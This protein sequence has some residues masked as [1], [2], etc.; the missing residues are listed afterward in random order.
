MLV[1]VSASPQP[2]RSVIMTGT[3][4]KGTEARF[5]GRCFG[6]GEVGQTIGSLMGL[7]KNKEK[8]VAR[9]PAWG[10]SFFRVDLPS[11]V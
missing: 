5:S 2:S 8:R 3:C 7:L 11:I 9:P 4:K 6:M 1:T 10:V